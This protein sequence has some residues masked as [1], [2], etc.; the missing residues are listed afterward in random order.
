MPAKNLPTKSAALEDPWN[1]PIKTAKG[2][3]RQADDTK[4]K[5]T[6]EPDPWKHPANN[7]PQE[8]YHLPGKGVMDI[9]P[10]PPWRQPVQRF[11]V[12]QTL[13]THA[14]PEGYPALTAVPLRDL[15]GYLW[16]VKWTHVPANVAYWYSLKYRAG[17]GP[18]GEL[19]GGSG[20]IR[21]FV[22]YIVAVSCIGYLF[23]V[24]ST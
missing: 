12:D 24:V 7:Q 3:K 2:S 9:N 18:N 15:P 16:R 4:C 14:K 19:G 20:T 17:Y 6:E 13:L 21:P 8:P 10:T 11:S 1:A 22:H 5:F 23:H